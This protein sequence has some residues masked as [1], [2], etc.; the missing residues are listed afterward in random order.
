MSD[1]CGGGGVKRLLFHKGVFEEIISLENLLSAWYEFRKEKRNKADIQKFERYLENNIFELHEELVT[2][3]Y[4]HSQYHQF[5]ITDPKL[6]IISKARVKDRLLHKAI[7]QVLYPKWDKTLIHDSYSCRNGKGA[8]K[9]FARLGQITRKVSKNYAQP[10]F[11]L[12]CDI[13]KFFD[14]VDHNIL[15]GLLE[16]RIADEKLLDLLKNIIQSFECGPGKGMPLGNLTSQLFANVYMNP[17]D[18]FVKHKLKA[19]H[20]L[21]YADDFILL[22]NSQDELLGYLVEINQFLKSRLKLNLHPDKISV[23]KL[24]WGIDYVGYIVLPY[25]NLPRKKTVERIFKNLSKSIAMDDDNLESRYQSYLG[26]LS[27]TSSYRI[28]G[29]LEEMLYCI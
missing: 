27:Y 22:S 16:E 6:R 21:R 26:Y 10:C 3:S 19:K 7:Y 17:L 29:Q 1:P 20:Y 15:I 13:R 5:Q 14:S 24:N 9:A 18:K 23:R 2:G 11:A 4:S 8:H 12:K 25:Y 28:R